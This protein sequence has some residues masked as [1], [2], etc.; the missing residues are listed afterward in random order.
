MTQNKDIVS[1]IRDQFLNRVQ[2]NDSHGHLAQ[3]LRV[4]LSSVKS[5]SAKKLAAVYKQ[6][7][8]NPEE[9]DVMSDCER[10]LRMLARWMLR[11]M[12][13]ADDESHVPLLSLGGEDRVSMRW[14]V[15]WVNQR[16]DSPLVSLVSDWLEQLVFGQHVRVALSRF[17]GKSQKLRFLL[18]DHGIV[19]AKAMADT[20]GKVI[21]GWTQDRLEAFVD[22]L[23]DVGL[24]TVSDDEKL[25]LGTRHSLIN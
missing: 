7:A 11:V 23:C 24:V 15:D 12:A 9:D 6:A 5:L 19:L 1:R 21:P 25:E 13:W 8:T 20:R 2:A 18:D 16:R 3:P 4:E 10:A 17:D 22:L 14:F